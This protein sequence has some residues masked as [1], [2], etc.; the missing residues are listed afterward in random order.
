MP[1]NTAS[2]NPLIRAI[3]GRFEKDTGRHSMNRLSV[4]AINRL[5]VIL[6]FFF[7]FMKDNYVFILLVASHIYLFSDKI[8]KLPKG[9]ASSQ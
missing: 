1:D 8:K 5:L 3:C 7:L 4:L 9:A 6:K 2:Y